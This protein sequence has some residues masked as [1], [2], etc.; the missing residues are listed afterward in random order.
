MTFGSELRKAREA[1][2][3]SVA[4]LATQTRIRASVIEDLERDRY[5]STGGAAYARGHIR[6]IA[7]ILETD[8]EYLL[9]LFDN[10]I[11][12]DNRTINAKLSDN[13][14]TASQDFKS[15]L[16]RKSTRLNSSH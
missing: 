15:P 6:V 10:Q 9:E 16:D 14:A 2:G 13:S 4:Q 5:V 1:A 8:A 3:I 7:K 12:D 11:D